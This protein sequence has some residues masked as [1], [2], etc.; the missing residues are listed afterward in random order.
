MY[1]RDWE[2]QI[3]I[4]NYCCFGNKKGGEDATEEEIADWL[5]E[6]IQW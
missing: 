1:I 2:L 6:N 5:Y 4:K 3:N